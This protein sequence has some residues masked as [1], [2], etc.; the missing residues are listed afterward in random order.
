MQ[1]LKFSRRWLWR[2]PSSEMLRRVFLRSLLRFLVTA[3]F[4]LSS[5]ILVALM[6]EAKRSSKTPVLTRAKRRNISEDGIF[7]CIRRCTSDWN[8][9]GNGP[10]QYIIPH[11]W[12]M[13]IFRSSKISQLSL[14]SIQLLRRIALCSLTL[15]V[16]SFLR[17]RYWVK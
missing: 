7:Q 5:P 2:M 11:K 12:L 4:V 16:Y 14:L 8:T 15:T 9:L 6:T 3:N 10:G 1:D 13:A 17:Q